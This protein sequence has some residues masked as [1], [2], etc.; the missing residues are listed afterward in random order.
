LLFNIIY[1]CILIHIKH[2]E[3]GA[4]DLVKFD[5]GRFSQILEIIQ[6][7]I[8]Y[9]FA[10]GLF[11]LLLERI[12]PVPDETKQTHII[13]FEVLAQCVMSALSVFYLRKIVKIV[14]FILESGTYKTH[15]VDEYNGEIMIAIVFVG[16]QKNLI[17]KIEILR[18]RFLSGI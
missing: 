8:L 9:A 6:Y 14:P 7:S 3:R 15:N 16:I 18:N 4:N 17:T 11:G 1:T 10:A 2:I 13:L 12:F 5:K